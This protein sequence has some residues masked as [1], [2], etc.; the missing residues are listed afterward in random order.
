MEREQRWFIRY[1]F[2]VASLHPYEKAI[3]CLCDVY[4]RCSEWGVTSPNLLSIL[5]LIIPRYPTRGAEFLRID[6][7]I[8]CNSL[9]RSLVFL[10]SV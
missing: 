2:R 9:M 6:L 10:I 7:E 1:A 3:D 4:F 8:E 5:D